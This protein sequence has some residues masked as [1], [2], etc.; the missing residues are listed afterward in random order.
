M[1][2]KSVCGYCGVGCGLEFEKDRLVGDVIYPTNEGKVCSKGVSELISIQTP[3]RLLRPH[4]R[5]DINDDFKVSSWEDTIN[6]IAKKILQTPKEKIG[7]YLSG[8]LLTE[9]YYIANKLGKG[10]IGTNNVDTNSRTC[11]ASAVVAYKKSI[12]IDYVPVSM[13]D[14][15]QS[16]LLILIGANT[17]EAHVVFH[18]RIKKAKKAGL[19]IVVIDPRFTDT[20]KIADLYLPIKPGSDIDLLN[21]ISK[22]I[23]DEDL[24]D[25]DFVSNHVNNFDLL[26]NKFKRIPVT[27]MLKRT[28]LTKEQFEDFWILFKESPNIISAWT[29]GLNQSV[30]GVDKNLAL[31]NIHLL[32]GK[33]FKL[34]NGPLSLTGQPN[35]MGGREVGGLSTMLA[36]HLGFDKESIKKVNEFWK[37]NKV[38][39]SKGL[40]ATEMLDN[41][42][43]VLIICHT[44]PVYHLPNRNKVEQLIKKIP[45]VVEINAYENSESAKFSHIRLPAA[46]WGEK[47]GTQ[48]NLD[49]TVTKQ[50]KLTRTSIDCKPDWEI[51]MLIAHQLGFQNEFN[52]KC[53]EDIFKEYQEMTKLNPHI[54]MYDTSY[55]QL[56]KEPFIWGED[57]RKN[58]QFFTPNKK[59]NLHFVENKLLSEKTNLK[60]PFILLT[61]RT[62]DQWHS[63]TKTNLPRTLLKYKDLNFCEISS[64][65]AKKLN[66]DDGDE[67]RVSSKR[68]EI[69]TKALITD[70]INTGTIFI[71]ISNREI[72]YLTNDLL[73]KDSLQPDY[74]HSA[75]KIEK[76]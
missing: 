20:A 14:I 13:N 62:R 75:V 2:I 49:R 8:Q 12:G 36:V 11:M 27:K 55:E 3:T 37:T 34:G 19:K 15:F 45:F 69:T 51:F 61:G 52:Y 21:L 48:T 18:N 22:R 56:E 25:H 57:I 53:P 24:I 47:E 67:I 65:D 6:T 72:N 5:E 73:D 42:L 54:N 60:Y 4:I 64:E 9:D 41:K 23:I 32:T 30:Q 1:L 74:N 71:P 50:E 58:R 39:D 46:P 35:A 40:T 10:F 63:G 70:S 28:G 44:D 26:V 16:N 7:F 31:I 66:I 43:D 33:I 17:A 76:N 68:G 29:M 59:A 38:N